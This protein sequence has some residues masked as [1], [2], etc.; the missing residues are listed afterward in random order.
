[1]LDGVG[2]R[3]HSSIVS[4]NGDLI[5]QSETGI[6]SLT[7]L[8]NALFP[9]DLDLGLPIRKLTVSPAPTTRFASGANEPAVIALAAVPFGQYWI[10][11]PG[12]WSR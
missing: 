3:H 10:S 6:R 8:S 9:T 2:T 5:F 1:M 4:L 11:A 12:R 7:T